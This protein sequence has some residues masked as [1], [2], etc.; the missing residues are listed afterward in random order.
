MK[1]EPLFRRYLR[2]WRSDPRRDVDDEL[3]FHIAMRQNEYEQTGLDRGDAERAAHE[4]FGDMREVHQEVE[5]LAVARH[6]R[7]R[8]AKRLDAL[9]NDIAYALRSLRAK[10][11]YATAVILTLAVGIGAN[12]AIFAVVNSVLLRPLS[13]REP[14]RLVRIVDDLHGAGANDVGMSIP[15]FR[16]IASRTDVFEGASPILAASTALAGGDHV[17]RVQLLGTGA[18]YF[19]L[20]GANAAIGHVYTNA[21][22]RPGFIGTVVISDALWRRQFGADRG[23]I[24]KTLR[25]D[26]DPYTII[27]VM[28]PEFRHPA[29]MVGGDVDVW[30]GTGFIA[31]PFPPPVRGV[32]FLPGV[33]ARLHRGVSLESAQ[34]ALN[35]TAGRLAKTYPNEYPTSLHWSLRIER[36]Q[37]ALTGN[38]KPM[39]VILQAAV[40]AL[41][42]LVCV[43][44]A[45]LVL[46]RSSTRA[47]EI[48]LRQALGASRARI[49][50]QLFAESTILAMAGGVA[51][52]VALRA[53]LHSLIGIVPSDLPRLNEVHVDARVAIGA[54]ALS[55]VAGLAVGLAPAAFAT[56]V[57]PNEALK[58]GG[59]NGSA[60]TARGNRWRSAL[61]ITEVALSAMLLIAACLL[62]RSF[63]AVLG[64]NPGF[65]RAGVIAG[66]I[67]VPVPNNPTANKYLDPQRQAALVRELL[68]HFRALPGV[69]RA[70]LGSGPDLPLVGNHPF[71]SGFSL[72]DDDVAHA[73][74]QAAEFGTVSAEY[75]S[76]LGVPIHHGRAFTASDNFSAPGVV[77]VNDAFVRRFSPG[78]D[79]IGRRVRVPR[80][81]DFTVVGISG[82][83]RY[84]GLDVP[85]E[86]RVYFSIAQRPTSGLAFFVRARDDAAST[87]ESLARAVHEV[88]PNLP[89]FGLRSMS[90]LQFASMARRRF[91]LTLM[92]VF[93]VAAA[94]LAALG[95]FGVMS[96]LV[97]QRRQEFGLR[98]ALGATPLNIAVTAARP[99]L[100]LSAAGTII[101]VVGALLVTQV[102]SS[103]LFGV[104]ARDLLTFVAVPPLLLV[105]ALAACLVPARRATLVDPATALRS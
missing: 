4:R 64:Q 78:Q 29:G 86:P 95:I 69:D 13:L 56:A 94:L 80:A 100:V 50:R 77:V 9:R 28:P 22:W 38:V 79:L 51:A 31:D 5:R 15:E 93:A 71:V 92:S 8:R 84:A 74:D 63:G 42:L 90:D 72:P 10:P 88:D 103:L 68:D 35:G 32:R 61:V 98:R 37:A 17:E 101:G 87:R 57:D 55:L 18:N 6:L 14:D 30:A 44:V 46:A 1:H 23:I 16:D 25:L 21:D 81:G 34:A 75:F 102:M 82:D 36:V 53:G 85:T 3:A 27:G 47:R 41:L 83:V 7:Q 40:A 97:G 66:Q 73:D 52:V 49:A 26:E 67:W 62:V 105:V 43:N 104:S 76:T 12:L 96:F 54:I 39:L 19:E 91:S 45:S 70:A 20:L 24:G 11:L 33:L 60:A 59:R 58:D 2:F 99:G 65:S 89:V 48:A